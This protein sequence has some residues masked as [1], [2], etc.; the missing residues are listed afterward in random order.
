[1][2]NEELNNE[3]KIELTADVSHLQ[4]VAAQIYI[5]TA[6]SLAIMDAQALLLSKIDSSVTL[7]DAKKQMKELRDKRFIEIGR[8]TEES[9][10]PSSSHQ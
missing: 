4:K 2:E 6:L 9:F 7:D 10:P 1:M 3:L 8:K 5:N